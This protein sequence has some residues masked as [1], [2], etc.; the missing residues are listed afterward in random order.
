[1]KL[2]PFSARS[3]LGFRSLLRGPRKEPY[4]C[5]LPGQ[6]HYCFST[7]SIS[8]HAT[9]SDDSGKKST[10]ISTRGAA[11]VGLL[12]TYLADARSIERYSP[13]TANGALQL[14]VAESLIIED[15]LV[16]IINEQP[17][18]AADCICYQSTPGRLAA[19]Q[20]MASYM[21][22]LL[23]LTNAPDPENIVLG[24]GC[25]AVL[26]NLCMVL[27]DVGE[28]ILIPTPYY[29]AFEFDTGARAGLRVEPVT[30]I[31]YQPNSNSQKKESSTTTTLDPSIYYPTAASLDA[32]YQRCQSV[33][34]EPRILLLSH[35]H[36]PLGIC[37]PS[38]V[39]QECIEWA[40]SKEIHIISDEIYAGSIYRNQGTN[41]FVSALQ[42]YP[43][44]PYVHWIYSLSKDFCASGL[45][46]GA[47]YTSNDSIRVPLQKLNDLC[48]LPS[49]T[50]IWLEHVLTKQAND[51]TTTTTTTNT[52]TTPTSWTSAF[53]EA[54]H[55]R[56]R[57]RYDSLT[58]VLREASIPYLEA[59][60]GLFLWIDFSKYLPENGTPAERER[61]LYLE[62][63]QDHGLLLT[64]GWSMRNEQ[65][66]FFRCVFTAANESEFE[67][68]L[69]RLRKFAAS[70]R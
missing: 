70:K 66:G 62:L 40:I 65:P 5:S 3:L 18:A 59:S 50:Q 36:N 35:P 31:M 39:L 52:T 15:W 49:T 19:R 8:S 64:P 23:N 12:P 45:R 67:L 32:A 17:H 28:S 14:G 22:E 37:Y 48:Q 44:H 4:L 38:N 2:S 20:A 21:K 42:L 11:A 57:D 58:Q 27:A 24:A 55:Q 56:L 13:A 61:T 47:L 9:G 26:E 6:I 33:G 43:N 7:T 25:N 53:R 69:E 29:A 16:P 68:A 46:V 30:T 60:A 54:N 34:S 51:T 10:L 41:T 63:V 1:M